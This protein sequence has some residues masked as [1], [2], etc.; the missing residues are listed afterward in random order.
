MERG[1]CEAK[2]SKLLML[3]WPTDRQIEKE[4]PIIYC[5][6]FRTRTVPE[7]TESKILSV[8]PQIN[9]SDTG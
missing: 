1:K 8:E 7:T 5:T 3:L 4:L 6:V 2:T 9:V